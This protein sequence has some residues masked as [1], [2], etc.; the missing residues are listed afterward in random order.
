MVKESNKLSSWSD[1][2]SEMWT[3]INAIHS[4]YGQYMKLLDHSYYTLD[5]FRGKICYVNRTGT[6]CTNT[7]R[8]TNWPDDGSV[9]DYSC[10]IGNTCQANVEDAYNASETD[11]KTVVKEMLDLASANTNHAHFHYVYTSIAGSLTSD[12]TAHAAA[13]NPYTANYV[14]ST[15]TG[16]T[17]YV[18]ADYIGN[19]NNGG[20]E[21]LRTIVE[22]N[23]KY[24]FKGRSYEE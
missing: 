15:L 20:A 12:L 16:P 17:G 13:M 3:A 11:K 22:Q 21:L 23:F 9:T 18:Y 2:S 8:I 14:S 19:A 7:V 10:A 24:V 1:R 6:D 5:D 4:S